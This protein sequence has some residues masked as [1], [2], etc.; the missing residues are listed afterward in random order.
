MKH[1]LSSLGEARLLDRIYA[2]LKRQHLPALVLGPGDDAGLLKVAPGKILVATHDDLA[3]GAHFE[4]RWT[5]FRRLGR[6]LLRVNLSDLAAMGDVKPL[7]V[8]ATAAFPASAPERWF[9]D[10]LDGLSADC[11]LFK[12]AL[13]GGN[14]VRSSRLFFGLTALGEANPSGILRRSGA[15]PGDLLYGVGPLGLAGRGLAA[16]RRRAKDPAGVTAFWEPE[17]QFRAARLLARSR[18]AT[19]LI[20]NSDGLSRSAWEIAR[21][22]GTSF[23]LDLS[24]APVAGNPDAGEDYGLLFSVPPPRLARLKAVLPAAYPLGAVSKRGARALSAHGGY[25][26]FAA[27]AP[28]AL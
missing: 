2:R 26:P 27:K 24:H 18:L 10:F 12:T 17:P 25:D 3:E 8:L 28:H 16:L 5:D 21:A 11:R 23:R 6:K 15:K 1:V 9:R 20:D 14:L 19:A 13:L 22:S 7:A 4:T